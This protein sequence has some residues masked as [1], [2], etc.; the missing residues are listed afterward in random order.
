[1]EN[2]KG[3][4]DFSDMTNKFDVRERSRTSYQMKL[5]YILF[6]NT[7][8]TFTNNDDIVVPKRSFKYFK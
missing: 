3:R 1:M 4:S 8:E 7:D 2:N 6:S 5:E